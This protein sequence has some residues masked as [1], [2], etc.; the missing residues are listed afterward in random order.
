MTTSSELIN[1]FKILSDPNRMKIFRLLLDGE[2]CNCELNQ[3]T[4][5]S[6]NLLSHH[7]KILHDAGLI[8]AVHDP[9]DTRWIHYSINHEKIQSVREEMNLLF[10]IPENSQRTPSCPP[11]KRGKEI[12]Q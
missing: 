5:L 4:G 3:A 2:Y 9:N 8:D 1:I 10:E 11:G 6:I 7:L 12:A